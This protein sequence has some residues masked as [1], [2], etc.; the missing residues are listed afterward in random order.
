MTSAWVDDIEAAKARTE[1]AVLVGRP[2]D[3]LGPLDEPIRLCAGTGLPGFEPGAHRVQARRH[4]GYVAPGPHDAVARVETR[5]L[6]ELVRLETELTEEAL[7][8]IRHPAPA[9]TQVEVASVRF[10]NARA[11]A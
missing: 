9:W 2:V 4:V 11:T 5:Q 10:P 3:V 7:A 8:E 6:V 1:G